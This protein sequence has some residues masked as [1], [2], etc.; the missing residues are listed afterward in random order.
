MT[1]NC[2]TTRTGRPL[3]RARRDRP[4]VICGRPNWCGAS[5]DGAIAICMRVADGS[6]R[7][8]RN[9]GFVHVLRPQQ[10]PYRPVERSVRID[11]VGAS[12]DKSVKL[13]AYYLRTIREG[14]KL[15]RKLAE[16]LRLPVAPLV[17]LQVGWSKNR[18]ASAWPMRS[19]LGELLGIRYRDRD[20]RKLSLRG[21]RE[22]LFLPR[23]LG[24]SIDQ[25][26]L[27]EGGTD[28]AAAL[29]LG[30]TAVGRPSCTGGVRHV[31]DLVRRFGVRDVVVV[32]DRD[33]PGRRGA[34]S[35]A[36][37]L[38]AYVPTVRIIEP[39]SGA[40][41][42]RDAVRRGLRATDLVRAIETTDV[43]TL[44]VGRCR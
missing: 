44:R 5:A 24:P 20:G 35:I 16:D 22:G 30:F 37:V 3:V 17:R 27:P 15:L 4:C 42:L 19:A 34:A 1:R 13:F 25:L 43:L 14:P 36:A 33:E 28:T 9:G 8:S 21:G 11:D 7:P 32:A 31:V 29:A 38:R 10:R 26:L 2:I 40:R 6:V 12:N 18:Q 23:D 41:D 39:P